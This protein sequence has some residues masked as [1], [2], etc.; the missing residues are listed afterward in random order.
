MSVRKG[1]PLV[2]LPLLEGLMILP[3]G[4]QLVVAV[5]LSVPPHPVAMIS[6]LKQHIYA[7]R[8]TANAILPS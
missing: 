8:R 6:E 4:V 7:D 5:H 2:V 3:G 1:L